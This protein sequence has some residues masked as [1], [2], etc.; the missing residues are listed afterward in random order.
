[1]ILSMIILLFQKAKRYGNVSRN[2]FKVRSQTTGLDLSENQVNVDLNLSII[3]QFQFEFSILV[4]N[5]FW[6]SSKN[7]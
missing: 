3:F 2:N 5:Q 6:L 7:S 4:Q 1:M